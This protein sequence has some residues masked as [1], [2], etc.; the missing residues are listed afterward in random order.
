MARTG[1][2]KMEGVANNAF[3]QK[4]DDMVSDKLTSKKV[5]SHS[6]HR[7]KKCSN[8]DT[9]EV[10]GTSTFDNEHNRLPQLTLTFYNVKK[11]LKVQ[12]STS[13]EKLVTKTLLDGVSG[14]VK[15]GQLLALMGP[16][17]S[18]KT[19]LLNTLAGRT[20]TGV[21][22]TILLNG[23]S[24]EKGMKRKLAYVVQEDLFF[25]NLTVEEHLTYTALLRLPGHYTKQEKLSQVDKI[26]DMLG[27]KNCA[28]TTIALIS[29]GEKKRVNIG[30]ELLTGP[31]LIFLDGR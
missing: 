27:L 13:K 6:Q 15:P 9:I 11:V 26:I 2:T 29:G 12:D 4:E 17:G 8:H 21:S 28:S 25:D 24:Y 1:T 22:G 23:I 5:T 14:E 16:S 10:I 30:T 20:L 3:I 7:N 19:T 18:G 31:N